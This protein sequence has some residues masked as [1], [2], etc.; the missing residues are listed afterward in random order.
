MSTINSN[1]GFFATSLHNTSLMASMVQGIQILDL[2]DQR[3]ELMDHAPDFVIQ[4]HAAMQRK[5]SAL[6]DSFFVVEGVAADA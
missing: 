4:N 1:R 6:F 3:P 5:V 2:Y